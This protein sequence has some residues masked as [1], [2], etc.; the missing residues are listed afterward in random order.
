MDSD[1]RIHRTTIL[2]DD[3]ERRRLARLSDIE[4]T[5][6]SA[7]IRGLLRKHA[8]RVGLEAQHEQS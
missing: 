7:L 8:W 6:A 3:R 5:T 2:L 1:R 4:E